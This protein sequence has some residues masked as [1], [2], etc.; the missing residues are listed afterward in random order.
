M[1]IDSMNEKVPPDASDIA[2]SVAESWSKPNPN[3][4][5]GTFE[6]SNLCAKHAAANIQHQDKVNGRMP[7]PTMWRMIIIQVK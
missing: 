2:F 5:T 4:W 3:V 7:K 1:S 6:E